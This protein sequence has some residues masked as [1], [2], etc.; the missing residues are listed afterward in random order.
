MTEKELLDRYV[1]IAEMI[2]VMFSPFTETVVVDHR[3]EKP[4]IYAIFNNVITGRTVGFPTT[5]FGKLR[6][7]HNIPD[8]LFNYSNVGP[9]QQKIKSS[10]IA[11][12]NEDKKLIGVLAIHC[13]LETFQSLQNTLSNFMQTEDTKE[14]NH[15]KE[16]F[17]FVESEEE[18]KKL[19]GI[20]KEKINKSGKL[21]PK[22]LREK[23]MELLIES[24]VFKQKKA[25]STISKELN[26][27]RQW[28]YTFLRDK[29]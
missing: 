21:A 26:V 23:L 14:I 24:N 9:K 28:I 3:P 5:D 20:L 13:E 29:S 19:I 16:N 18:I 12:R 4:T 7:T 15:T 1:V 11:I 2:S 27:S 8:K 17:F 6:L 10:A 22:A 25:I